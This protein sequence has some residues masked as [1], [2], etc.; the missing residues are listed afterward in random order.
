MFAVDNVYSGSLS[1]LVLLHLA[2]GA[3]VRRMIKKMTPGE[4]GVAAFFIAVA[5]FGIVDAIRT[6]LV[7]KRL[8]RN[9]GFTDT[10]KKTLAEISDS[11]LV[12]QMYTE[13]FHYRE[14][15]GQFR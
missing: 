7:V 14:L 6:P 5:L 13:H 4:L 2:H 12:G 9:K 1:I 8:Y 10:G 11:R 3:K 15:A